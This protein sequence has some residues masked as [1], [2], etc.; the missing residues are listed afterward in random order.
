MWMLKTKEDLP[1]SQ[2][3]ELH[4]LKALKSQEFSL[5]FWE[6]LMWI[7]WESGRKEI[8]TKIFLMFWW[9]KKAGK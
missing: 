7:L 4:S 3:S 5:V 6:E 8:E 2:G 1:R 9:E